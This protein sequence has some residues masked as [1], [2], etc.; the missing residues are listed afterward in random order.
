MFDKT[1]VK[2]FL[3]INN[4]FVKSRV[5]KKMRNDFALSSD[6]MIQLKTK[7]YESFFKENKLISVFITV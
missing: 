3:G 7:K 1:P 2:I 4:L 6:E 5:L